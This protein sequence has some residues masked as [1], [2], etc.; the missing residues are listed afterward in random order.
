LTVRTQ[1]DTPGTSCYQL[2]E[3]YE[4]IT[5]PTEE[6]TSGIGSGDFIQ[7]TSAMSTSVQSTQGRFQTQ[8]VR[9]TGSSTCD[10]ALDTSPLKYDIYWFPLE[11]TEDQ[12][13]CQQRQSGGVTAC[14]RANCK[15]NHRGPKL[16][17]RPGTIL[18]V[19][20]RSA[21]SIFIE[22][23]THN[24]NISNELM[25]EWRSGPRSLDEWV[26]IFRMVNAQST[27]EVFTPES[28][29]AA[30]TFSKYAKEFKS[31]SNLEV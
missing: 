9:S 11:I 15:L 20:A 6:S 25:N 16:S 29:T 10:S 22:P 19:V 30:Q 18:V 8:S 5:Q 23:S 31:P 1:A 28:L 13:I 7:T 27:H 26:D 4:N 21:L 2:T 24:S 3:P 14:I 12:S 17:F